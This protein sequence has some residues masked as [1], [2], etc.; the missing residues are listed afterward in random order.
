M[1]YDFDRQIQY[2]P[3]IDE[4]TFEGTDMFLLKNH[5]EVNHSIFYD[6]TVR[7]KDKVSEASNL[8][9]CY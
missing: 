5:L 4:D 1:I 2:H 7:A 3:K 8:S 9:L 6:F